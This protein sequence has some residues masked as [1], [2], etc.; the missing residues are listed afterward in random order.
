MSNAATLE[1]AE[2]MSCPVYVVAARDDVESAVP[3]TVAEIK[4]LLQKKASIKQTG[5]RQS[6]LL[7]YEGGRM[8]LD[9]ELCAMLGLMNGTEVVIEK[10][11]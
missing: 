10:K 2:K 7:L 1:H 6:L 11:Y 4:A 3:D 9:G 5:K 8:L